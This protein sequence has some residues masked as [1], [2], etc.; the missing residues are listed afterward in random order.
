MC[1]DPAFDEPLVV[2]FPNGAVRAA[3]FDPNKSWWDPATGEPFLFFE[4]ADHVPE[5]PPVNAVDVQLGTASRAGA[6]IIPGSW[7]V[8]AMQDEDGSGPSSV[9]MRNPGG[10]L[11][12]EVLGAEDLTESEPSVLHLLPTGF[13]RWQPDTGWQRFGPPD[14][15]ALAL[16]P[17]TVLSA[18]VEAGAT[19]LP[20]F[21]LE[22]L[23]L[24]PAGND[25]FRSGQAIVLDPGGPAEEVLRLAS[26][27]SLTLAQPT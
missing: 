10:G 7:P 15:D 9:R 17:Q 20:V 13:E 19:V 27:G 3:C 2:F 6:Y 24:D 26:P 18:S 16:L 8:R 23:G 4:G 22:E 11:P 25:W 14:V 5:G 1:G 12:R 21:G